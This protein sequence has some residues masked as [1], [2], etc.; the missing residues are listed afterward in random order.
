MLD[1]PVD[2]TLRRI[3]PA[4]DLPT[5]PNDVNGAATIHDQVVQDRALG[6]ATARVDGLPVLGLR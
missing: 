6:V 2:D 1:V 5:V 3:D 4:R